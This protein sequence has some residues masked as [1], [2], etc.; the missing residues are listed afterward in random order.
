M[1]TTEYTHQDG[2]QEPV[3]KSSSLE[4]DFTTYSGI[5]T[6]HLGETDTSIQS[7]RPMTSPYDYTPTVG[8][9]TMTSVN[10]PSTNPVAPFTLL[11]ETSTV[12]IQPS[13][14]AYGSTPPTEYEV[15]ASVTLTTSST[16]QGAHF[17][18]VTSSEE[19]TT[20]SQKPSLS[21]ST[22]N[23]P[24]FST[25]RS[26]RKTDVSSTVQSSTSLPRDTSA[27]EDRN[28]THNHDAVALNSNCSYQPIPRR[29]RNT[30]TVTYRLITLRESTNGNSKH[31][32]IIYIFSIL[33]ISFS[34]CFNKI[35]TNV[36]Y[37]M[38]PK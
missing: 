15:M 18:R 36:A 29:V 33:L 10:A 8:S 2:S 21:Y 35:G 9:E 24:L 19:S 20:S 26:R 25:L 32:F 17:T 22:P 23:F 28:L 6:K 31:L 7:H 30:T 13:T 14:S 12:P 27:G 37:V 1:E 11:V 3:M 34:S 4:S 5:S 38:S 16:N